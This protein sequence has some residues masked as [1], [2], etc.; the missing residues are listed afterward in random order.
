MHRDTLFAA[1]SADEQRAL[2]GTDH[3]RTRWRIRSNRTDKGPK[4]GL[5]ISTPQHPKY[6]ANTQTIRGH[7]RITHQ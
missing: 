5:T 1:P 7:P 4:T 2:I 6:A 3:I